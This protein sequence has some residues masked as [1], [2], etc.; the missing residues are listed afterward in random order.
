MSDGAHAVESDPDLRQRMRAA[1][2]TE[3]LER[4][5]VELTSRVDGHGQSLAREF[6]HVLDV[7]DRRAYV[8]AAGWS[9][10]ERGDVLS[11]LFHESDLLIAECVL[12]GVFDGLDAAT[13]AG[14]LSVFVYEHRSPEP[15]APPWFPSKDARQRWQ[16]IVAW[17]DDLAADERSGGLAEHR[18]PDPGFVAA[19]HGWVAGEGLAEVVGDEELTGGDFVRTMKQLVDLARQIAVV[20]PERG[21]PRRAA[22]VAEQ[23]FRG[24]VADSVVGVAGLTSESSSESWVMVRPTDSI[25][26]PIAGSRGSRRSAR[27]RTGARSSPRRPISST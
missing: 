1:G 27:A 26:Q 15:P 12:D 14:L 9:L 22:E 3:R 13:L 6:D 19:A 23:A 17:S 8:D 2:Q 18:P 20:A 5:L 24:V 25:E 11:R 7:L 4:E 10:T 16:R 21:H